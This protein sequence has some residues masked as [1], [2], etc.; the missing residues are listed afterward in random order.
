MAASLLYALVPL[1]RTT[2]SSCGDQAI[3][4]L[5]GKPTPNAV[6]LM[7]DER[8]LAALLQN[9]AGLANTF[10]SFN[11]PTTRAATFSFRVE[12]E[13]WVHIVAASLSLPIPKIDQRALHIL[14]ASYQLFTSLNLAP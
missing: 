10:C 3:A 14:D 4:L 9:G 11:S 8:V 12:E 1:R 2:T 13:L 5:F 6:G 7:V